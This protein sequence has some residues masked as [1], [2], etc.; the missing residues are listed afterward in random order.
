MKYNHIY[1]PFLSSSLHV[2]SN[3]YTSQLHGIHMYIHVSHQ[4]EL[5][6]TEYAQE[7][8]TGERESYQQLHPPYKMISLTKARAQQLKALTALAEDLGSVLR[9]HVRQFATCYSDTEAL[10]SHDLH[11]HL[12]KQCT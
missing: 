7:P 5:M 2:T 9:T 12:H 1:L 3:I 11:R 6:L 4:E 10:I 8:S